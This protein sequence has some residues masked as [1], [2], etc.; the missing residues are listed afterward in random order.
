MSVEPEFLQYSKQ[1]RMFDSFECIWHVQFYDHAFLL[2]HF[3]GVN[4]FLDED[5]IIQ[6]LSSFDKNSLILGDYLM[7]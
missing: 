6:Y 4:G 5:D 3:A 1:N 7:Q 2:S